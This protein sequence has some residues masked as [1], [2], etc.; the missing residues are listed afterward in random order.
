MSEVF[1]WSVRRL[2]RSAWAWSR[3]V[4]RSR[5]MATPCQ[6]FALL[7]L[8]PKKSY[9]W[10]ILGG[11][12]HHLWS[13]LT[14]IERVTRQNKKIANQEDEDIT[15]HAEG[16]RSMVDSRV[17]GGREEPD[18]MSGVCASGV[19]GVCRPCYFISKSPIEC[20]RTALVT[21]PRVRSSHSSPKQGM[22]NILQ[23]SIISLFPP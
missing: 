2:R 13:Q 3:C 5:F 7:S 4:Q 16:R 19:R 21:P 14:I 18:L 11:G 9:P 1:V 17:W 8:P 23:P 12:A 10:R 20:L 22:P 6:Y 15:I